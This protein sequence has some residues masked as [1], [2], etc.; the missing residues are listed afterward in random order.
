MHKHNIPIAVA[1]SSSQNIMELKIKNHRHFFN[2]FHHI[3]CGT[4]DCEVLLGKPAPDIFLI[5]ASRFPDAPKPE[6]VIFWEKY[7]RY[8]YSFFL[9]LGVWRCPAWVNRGFRSR[10]A[11]C[12][13]T[14]FGLTWR[15]EAACNY[16]VE[17]FIRF[18]AWTFWIATILSGAQILKPAKK[19]L[20][21]INHRFIN[22]YTLINVIRLW[23]YLF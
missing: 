20:W 3:V 23:M 15:R 4:T 6:N 14:P 18:Q 8:T 12:T 1:T 5:C 16:C 19:V 21:W 22:N 13:S 10:N 11:S 9:V 2:L 7:T 17:V